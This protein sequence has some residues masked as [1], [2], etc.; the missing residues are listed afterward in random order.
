M[1][2]HLL[3]FMQGRSHSILALA[4]EIRPPRAGVFTSSVGTACR[5]RSRVHGLLRSVPLLLINGCGLFISRCA[6]L[7]PLT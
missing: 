1:P 6:L 5:L 3:L 4:L 7:M 2:S